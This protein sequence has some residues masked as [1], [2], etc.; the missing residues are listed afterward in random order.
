MIIATSRYW[1]E[2]INMNDEA[3]VEFKFWINNCQSLPQ[4]RFFAKKIVRQNSLH[5][6][7]QLRLRRFY[8]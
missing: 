4:N 3:K 2:I 8:C 6:R 1:D 7:K 5:R